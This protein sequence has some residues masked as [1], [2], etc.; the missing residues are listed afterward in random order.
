M[1]TFSNERRPCGSCRTLKLSERNEV[2]WA[3]LYLKVCA[4][5]S[6]HMM[7]SDLRQVRSVGVEPV[8]WRVL[9]AVKAQST[10]FPSHPLH[11]LQCTIESIL[12][13]C[14]SVWFGDCKVSDWKS[15][16][17]VV[18]T[19]EKIIGFPSKTSHTKAVWPGP[20]TLQKTPPIL[21]MDCFLCCPLARGFTAFGA[22]Q[23]DSATAFPYKLSDS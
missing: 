12:T 15:V 21:I 1:L 13:S 9:V 19:S 5:L 8:L 2:L 7:T 16:W 23:P 11:F 22:E 10:P 17:R 14:I 20:K 4:L 3:F 6:T 18:R